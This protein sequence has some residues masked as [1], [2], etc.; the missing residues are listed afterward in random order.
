MANPSNWPTTNDGGV[1][2]AYASS[3]EHLYHELSRIHSLIQGYTLR[4]ENANFASRNSTFESAQEE[5][6][7]FR[8]SPFQGHDLPLHKDYQDAL[9][10]CLANAG[11]LDTT[12]VQRLAVTPETTTLRLRNLQ[13]TFQLVEVSQ[14]GNTHRHT[15]RRDVLLLA[16]LAQQ[17]P[18][19]RQL[20]GLLQNDMGQHITSP[21]AE[22]TLRILEPNQAFDCLSWSVF[23]AD[24]PLLQDRLVTLAEVYPGDPISR[25]IVRL[26]DRILDYLFD[27][28]ALDGRLSEC[29][30][31]TEADSQ[32]DQLHLDQTTQERLKSVA[33]WRRGRSSASLLVLFHG[34]YGTPRLQ[35]AQAICSQQPNSSGVLVV[36]V[37]AALG[38]K[39]SWETFVRCCYREARLRN[40][41]VYWQNAEALLTSDQPPQLWKSLTTQAQREGALTFVA[42][43]TVWEPTDQFRSVNQ[44]VTR[45]D[46]FPPNRSLRLQIWEDRLA[47]LGITP[48]QSLEPLAN[49]FQ[50][51]EGQ[52]DDA[53]TTAQGI[54]LARGEDQPETWWEHLAEGCRRQSAR[55]LVSFAQRIEPRQDARLEDL[56]LPDP[57]HQQLRE[58]V[59]RIKDQDHIRY[60]LGFADRL[61]LGQGL[62]VMFTGASGTG[63]T[64]AA[65][66]LAAT[67]GVDL[68]K[69]DLA[70]IVSKY[71]GETEKNLGRLFTEAQ[72]AN[73]ILFF[74]E[75][76]SMFGKRG[77]VEEARDR[78]ANLE[79]N[80]LLQ[81]VEEYKGTVILATNFRQNIDEAFLRR[82]HVIVE[83]PFPEAD[84]RLEIFKGCFTDLVHR[85]SEKELFQLAKRFAISGG[86]IKNVVVDAVFRAVAANKQNPVV[87]L[88]HL[89]AA[90]AREYQKLGKPVTP[91]DFGSRYFPWVK[92]DLL[93]ATDPEW[94]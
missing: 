4:W 74:D 73:A 62:V 45:V 79:V 29:A 87:T 94:V 5:L 90:V 53:L 67:Q 24:S 66:L 47:K 6:Q 15:L 41:A 56:V 52:I 12:I 34:T 72:E 14:A 22:L 75:A 57:N 17:S 48:T 81:R 88:R 92:E 80:Y 50:F 38:A 63:K 76:D 78:W 55:R 31:Y 28:D 61:T 86:S 30:T 59:Q 89:I 2:V 84:A 16:M 60:G 43:E 93:L 68:Y 51:T 7:Q 46:F 1:P 39:D 70:A 83:F 26:D 3:Q 10:T 23:H 91:G 65:G 40:A 69:V 54:G 11:A 42:S 9:E 32:I 35:A 85:P 77:E 36:D 82:I 33:E 64:M 37:L 25:Q 8:S 71:V 27:G 13:R 19:H 20:F 21:T 58:L 18:V 44:H 49:S